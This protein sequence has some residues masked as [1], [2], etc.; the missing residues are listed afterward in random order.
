MVLVP[1]ELL[2]SLVGEQAGVETA[3]DDSYETADEKQTRIFAPLVGW[4][5]Q[6]LRTDSGDDRDAADETAVLEH[7]DQGGGEFE[8][9]PGPGELVAGVAAVHANFERAGEGVWSVRGSA[10][11][12]G[13]AGGSW[14][15]T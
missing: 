15:R 2:E 8:G 3:E 13:A 6:D 7:D 12:D 11:E 14:W 4:Q 9:G 1:G 10:S 5:G